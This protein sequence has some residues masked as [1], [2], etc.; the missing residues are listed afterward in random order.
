VYVAPSA[1]AQALAR[2]PPMRS[3]TVSI[4]V[5][6]WAMAKKVARVE[7]CDPVAE[8]PHREKTAGSVLEVRIMELAKMEMAELH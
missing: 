8:L 3:M 7:E 1:V 6:P 4:I 5:G 2:E